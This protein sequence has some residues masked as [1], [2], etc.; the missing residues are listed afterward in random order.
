[1]ELCT[2]SFLG[3]EYVSKRILNVKDE[4]ILSSVS[5]VCSNI[6]VKQNFQVMFS[7][8][9]YAYPETFYLGLLESI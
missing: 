9:G 4:L 8:D 3:D 7:T 1:M 6:D 2:F 5:L